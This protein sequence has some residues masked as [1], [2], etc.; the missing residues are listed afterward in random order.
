M[1]F[2]VFL[3]EVVRNMSDEDKKDFKEGFYAAWDL[4]F[5]EE[6]EEGNC[7]GEPWNYL[8]SLDLGFSYYQLGIDYFN[9]VRE[10][11]VRQHEERI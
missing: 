3:S 4:D 8:D 11:I 7:W 5:D 10:S 9:E 2:T 6:Q 1:E